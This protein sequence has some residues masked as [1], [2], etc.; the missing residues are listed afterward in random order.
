MSHFFAAVSAKFDTKFVNEGGGHITMFQGNVRGSGRVAEHARAPAEGATS[1]G[2]R[3]G[4]NG[5][6]D[7]IS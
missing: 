4:G 5:V 3:N 6:A 1:H 7:T 2:L